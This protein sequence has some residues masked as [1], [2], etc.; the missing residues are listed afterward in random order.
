MAA[1][2][3]SHNLEIQLASLVAPTTT[4]PKARLDVG[5]PWL[6]LPE[7][8][9]KYNLNYFGGLA[10]PRVIEKLRGLLVTVCN[11]GIFATCVDTTIQ[12]APDIAVLST[13]PQEEHRSSDSAASYGLFA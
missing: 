12:D 13:V 8:P 11:R 9:V 10:P 3:S 4:A 2:G 1:E 6:F 7:T 5:E